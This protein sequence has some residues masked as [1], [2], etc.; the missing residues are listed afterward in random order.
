[1]NLECYYSLELICSYGFLFWN[2][3]WCEDFRPTIFGPKLNP[4]QPAGL[5]IS[6]R[7]YFPFRWKT[8]TF[9]SSFFPLLVAGRLLFQL[10]KRY[11]LDRSY[12]RHPRTHLRPEPTDSEI[13][14]W[15]LVSSA[16]KPW[17]GVSIPDRDV[18]CGRDYN[19]PRTINIILHLL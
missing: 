15:P 17:P 13:V 12:Q 8:V 1:M 11:I 7:G 2:W 10:S 6:C 19:T 9:L 16:A 5:Q 4:R 14:R 3:K 18:T